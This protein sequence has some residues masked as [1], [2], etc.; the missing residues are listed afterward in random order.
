MSAAGPSSLPWAR[1]LARPVFYLGNNRLSQVGVVLTTVSAVTLLTFYTTEFFGVHPGPYTGII[2]FLTLPATFVLGLVLIPLGIANK[3]RRE[4]RTGLLPYEYPQ[5]N[6]ADPKLKE[7][8]LFIVVMTGVNLALF[9]T[10]T[11]RGVH[12]M[13]STQFCGQTCHTVMQPEYTAYQHSPHARVACV[14]CHIGAGAPWFVRSKLSGS[15]QVISVTFHLYSQPIPTPI[16]NLRPS[17]ETCEQCH[18]PLKFHGDKL[19][20]RSHFADDEVNS[21]TQTV[22][23]LHT[24]GLDPLTREPRGNHGVHLQPGAEIAYFATDFQRQQIP[25]VRYRRP[26]GEVIEYVASDAGKPAEQFRA[27]PLRPMD[28]MD[29]HNR[30]THIFQL[31][32]VALNQAL[33]AK[34]ID[35]SLPY[36]KKQGME[37]LHFRYASQEEAAREIP[38]RLRDFYRSQYPALLNSREAAIAQAGEALVGMYQ[39]NIFPQ[40]KIFWGTYPSNLGHDPFPGCFRCHDGS[41]STPDG[42]QTI[43]NDCGTCHAL[44]AFEESNPQ[45]LKTLRG[46]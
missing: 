40:M 45:I 14:E 30:P 12:Y 9:L 24:G 28:C 23:L 17:R 31:P 38:S 39:R 11:Y 8:V 15:Y 10:A 35:P 43:P 20:I 26:S 44:L 16:E 34:L 27:G 3:Y 5:I 33:E 46:E 37:V 19:V 29:C 36:I 1:R 18:W 32:D 6:L 41:H 13:D 2:F 25:Y 22:L 4:K 21:P 42:S 7:T